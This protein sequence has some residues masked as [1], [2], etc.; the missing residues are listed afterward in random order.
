M[1]DFFRFNAYF[2]KELTKYQPIS[3]DPNT[4]LNLMR[5]RSLEGFVA[6]VSPFNFTAIAGNLAYTPAM[7]VCFVFHIFHKIWNNHWNAHELWFLSREME[8]YGNLVIPQFCQIISFTKSSVTPDFRME[9][10]I[11]FPQM[12]QSLEKSLLHIRN[13]LQSISLDLFR[14]KHIIIYKY[15]KFSN[16]L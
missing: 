8:L 15:I 9:L 7:M 2:G 16:F 1:V 13:W 10:S 11:L 14:K 5:Y 3:E 6:S 12:V 4:T